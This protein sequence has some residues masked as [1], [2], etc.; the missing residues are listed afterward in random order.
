MKYN[1]NLKHLKTIMFMQLIFI[2]LVFGFII[3]DLKF[4]LIDNSIS[5][6]VYGFSF[7]ILIILVTILFNTNKKYNTIK[8][9]LNVDG[10]S[11]S[12][13]TINILL[14]VA[15]ILMINP[16]FA[17]NYKGH[18]GH[19][20]FVLV[21]TNVFVALPNIIHQININFSLKTLFELFSYFIVC[22]SFV[23]F[24]L[25]MYYHVIGLFIEEIKTARKTK[26]I[27]LISLIILNVTFIY[28]QIR[29]DPINLIKGIV[30]VICSTLSLGFSIFA[31]YRLIKDKSNEF[32]I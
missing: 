17:I 19:F 20:P 24:L 28:W 7:L 10:I 18:E 16:L 2:V 23:S 29:I 22:L 4:N 15:F 13:K 1:E 9:N 30:A 32:E 14:W 31:L 12:T 26:Y 11:S 5:T 8:K 3:V 25:L 21:Y 6:I 27:V